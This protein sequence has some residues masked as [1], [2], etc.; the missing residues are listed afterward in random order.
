MISGYRANDPTI[1][2]MEEGTETMAA[3]GF[4]D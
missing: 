4:A 2:G 1:K 3:F